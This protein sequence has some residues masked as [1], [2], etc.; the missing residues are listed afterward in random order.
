MREK[1]EIEGEY[2]CSVVQIK[3][4]ASSYPSAHQFPILTLLSTLTLS[5]PPTHS[6]LLS[7]LQIF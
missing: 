1:E 5:S 2:Q 6:A 3:V 7:L 4:L